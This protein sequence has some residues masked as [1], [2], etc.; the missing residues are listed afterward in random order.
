MCK[1][2]SEIIKDCLY[3]QKLTQKDLA[4][5]TG[6]SEATISHYIKGDRVPRGVNLVKISKVLNVSIDVLTSNELD[7]NKE[8]DLIYAKT[9]IA[10]NA[11]K[12]TKKEKIE[13]LS[14]LMTDGNDDE[15]R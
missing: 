5:L 10:R 8:N 2:I 11:S 15:I 7:K 13:L 14:L 1:N 4:N 3:S 6:L 9:L 12:M